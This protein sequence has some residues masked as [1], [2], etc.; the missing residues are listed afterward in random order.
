VWA[1]L[2]LPD[3]TIVS[4]DQEGAVQFWDGG[5]GTLLSRQQ[6]FAADVLALAASPDGSSVWASGVDPRVSQ[7]GVN[8]RSAGRLGI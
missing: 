3:G 4:G 8:S 5:F 6:H 7:P 2:V 1:L